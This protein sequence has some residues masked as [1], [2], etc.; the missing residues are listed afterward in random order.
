MPRT[1]S[2]CAPKVSTRL[3]LMLS[4][5]ARCFDTPWPHSV[6]ARLP[7]NGWV[8]GNVVC[9]YDAIAGKRA[10]TI[11]GVEFR[12]A[13]GRFC[14]HGA[15]LR[16]ASDRFCRSALARERSGSAATLFA[17]KTPSRASAPLQL[18]AAHPI[19][20]TPVA[21]LRSSRVVLRSNAQ[22]SATAEQSKPIASPHHTPTAP[23]FA[24]NPRPHARGAPTTQ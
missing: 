4:G 12:N 10:P 6:G 24:R 8:S 17:G 22:V 7:A 16:H 14:R 18:T 9:R 15:E 20:T 13:A 23:W 1:G 3:G 11:N 2:N 19:T 5:A 21:S